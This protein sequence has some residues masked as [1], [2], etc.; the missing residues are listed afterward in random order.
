MRPH[1]REHGEPCAKRRY[2]SHFHAIQRSHASV[3]VACNC[4]RCIVQELGMKGRWVAARGEQRRLQ[5]ACLG[6]DWR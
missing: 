1:K 6:K 5:T 3:E 2:W 4:L